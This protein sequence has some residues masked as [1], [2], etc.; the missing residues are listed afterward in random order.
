MRGMFK[1][2]MAAAS[3]YTGYRAVSHRGAHNPAG[4]GDANLPASARRRAAARFRWPGRRNDAG[5]APET[6]ALEAERITE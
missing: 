1:V 4:I 2:A 5:R 3:M 6:E